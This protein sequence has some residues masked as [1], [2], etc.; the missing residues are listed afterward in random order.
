M[1]SASS[2]WNFLRFYA[3]LFATAFKHSY[4]VAD[5]VGFVLG[6]AV[7][8]VGQYYPTEIS[9]VSNLVSWQI[10]L[11]A[12][13]VVFAVRF[14]LAPYWMYR[15]RDREAVEFANRLAAFSVSD[16][17]RAKLLD[18]W[19]TGDRLFNQCNNASPKDPVPTE[20]VDRWITEVEEFIKERFP[21]AMG[22]LYLKMFREDAGIHGPGGVWATPHAQLRDRVDN[23]RHRLGQIHGV[24]TTRLLSMLD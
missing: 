1:A 21:Y 10:P 13:G 18:L 5:A 24:V 20:E 4:G 2:F 8:I 3:R 9:A 22:E 14:V 11:L 23:R 17:T 19:L 15:E 6:L 12:L 7:G 16:A